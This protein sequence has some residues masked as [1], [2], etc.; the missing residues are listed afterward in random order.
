MARNARPCSLPD[1]QRQTVQ[2]FVIIGQTTCDSERIDVRPEFHS[3]APSQRA[4]T[5]MPWALQQLGDKN[6]SIFRRRSCAT[7]TTVPAVPSGRKQSMR[8]IG[9]FSD[10][11]TM[12]TL[13]LSP[14][15]GPIATIDRAQLL[16]IPASTHLQKGDANADRSLTAPIWNVSSPCPHR[17]KTGGSSEEDVSAPPKEPETHARF[18]QAH[19]HPSGARNHQPSSPQGAQEAHCQRSQ[20][21]G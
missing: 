10:E 14:E 1:K 6:V 18:P 8:A 20:E 3:Q 17:G 2:L 11:K 19:E 9:V 13:D 21:I 15:I 7:V 4:L 16:K 12:S 5:A